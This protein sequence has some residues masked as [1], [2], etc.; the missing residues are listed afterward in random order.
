M[1][2]WELNY[3]SDNYIMVEKRLFFYLVIGFMVATVIGTLSH[4]GGHY[5]VARSLGFDAS[6]NYRSTTYPANDV[7]SIKTKNERFLITLGGPVQ[8]ILTGT[9]GL[10]LLFYRRN[11]FGSRTYLYFRQ[12]VLIFLSL[13]WLRQMAIFLA[14]IANLLLAGEPSADL[15]EIKISRYLLFPD[16][17]IVS[18]TGITGIAV[19]SMIVFRFI[20]RTQR[21][22][23]IFSGIGGG[24][25]GYFLWFEW[26][27]K[28]I[29][30]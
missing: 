2:I 22:S 24:V 1:G 26:L 4:E 7:N 10:L 5:L 11:S 29:M 20:P 27:G 15:D 19:L 28:I 9:I 23:F 13:F 18:L 21:L 14:W 25:A 6:V 17:A 16:Y 8:T 30:P 12:W 3:L